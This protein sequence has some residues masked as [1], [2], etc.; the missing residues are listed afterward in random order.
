MPLNRLNYKELIKELKLLTS[1]GVKE[2]NILNIQPL[3]RRSRSKDIIMKTSVLGKYV[4]NALKKEGYL[5][6]K[7]LKILLV[8]FAPCALP[9]EARQYFF[10][11]LE[12]NNN[13][14]RIPLCENCSY[15]NKCDGILSD[16][17][18]LYGNREFRL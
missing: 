1:L 12:K 18:K 2:I 9:K 4:F 16:Y 5:N 11:C 15:K 3:S 14:I 17:I 7:G 6:K 8:E 13:K 10:P